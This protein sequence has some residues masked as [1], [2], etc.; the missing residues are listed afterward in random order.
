MGIAAF[1]EVAVGEVGVDVGFQLQVFGGAVFT[2]NGGDHGNTKD[3]GGVDLGFPPNGGA[4]TGHGFADGFSDAGLLVHV[5]KNKGIA[6]VAF[7]HKYAAGFGPTT[8]GLP[9]LE[10]IPL[11]GKVQVALSAQE[12]F[13]VVVQPA[14]AVETGIHHQALAIK[15]FAQDFVKN[16]P[17]RTI[18]HA[19]NVHITQ[20]ATA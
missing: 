9:V 20:G 7:A 12:G 15:I 8:H 13:E 14:S 17:E 2:T 16:I 3:H 4:G 19:L 18:V 1:E 6:V 10:A 11:R 5:R